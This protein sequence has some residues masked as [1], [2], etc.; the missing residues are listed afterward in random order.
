MKSIHVSEQGQF[1]AINWSFSTGWSLKMEVLF[2]AKN[3][4]MII[5]RNSHMSVGVN[6]VK[7]LVDSSP[8]TKKLN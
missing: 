6:S 3:K 2:L 8:L 7:K 4:F 1:N 5:K